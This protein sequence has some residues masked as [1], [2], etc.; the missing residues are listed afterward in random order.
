MGDEGVGVAVVRRLQQAGEGLPPGTELVDGGTLGL[1][2]LPLV[3]R[4]DGLIV[5]DA[6][7]LGALPGSFR[8][9]RGDEIGLRLGGQ[10]SSHE[11]GLADLLAAARLT[12]AL[13]EQVSLVGVQPAVV[14][15]GLELSTAVE[16]AVP[17]VVELVRRELEQLFV[18]AP[19]A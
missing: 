8:V 14:E 9:L 7:E 2:L 18:A 10:V 15:P 6:V 5:V 3:A 19:V 17:G 12:G 16:A 1:D 11:I 13:P 4:S